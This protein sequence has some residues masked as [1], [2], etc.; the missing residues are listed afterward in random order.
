MDSDTRALY[1]RRATRRAYRHAHA[2]HPE[3]LPPLP[4]QVEPVYDYLT[5]WS[6]IQ[7]GDLDPAVSRH[8]TTTLKHTYLKLRCVGGGRSGVGGGTDDRGRVY[9]R[10]WGRGTRNWLTISC[11]WDGHGLRHWP[12]AAVRLEGPERG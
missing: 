10:R 8:Y 6:G 1:T 12:Q 2:W 9:W 7:P 5:R 4:P 11:D 3:P